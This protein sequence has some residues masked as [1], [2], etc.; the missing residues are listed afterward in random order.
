MKFKNI[1]IYILA[2]I[3]IVFGVLCLVGWAPRTPEPDLDISEI[4]GILDE[5]AD[6]AI[7]QAKDR[8]TEQKARIAA[9]KN[10][11]KSIPINT[12]SD[13]TNPEA[14]Y[15]AKTLYG[16]AGFLDEYERSLVAWCILNRV[17][18]GLGGNTVGEVVS[19]PRQFDGY[20]STNPVTQEN[21]D[22]AVDVL[23]RWE[24]EKNGEEDV[25]RTLPAEY[26]YF[27]G[28]GKHNYFRDEFLSNES[29]YK[30]GTEGVYD[31]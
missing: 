16:E 20:S 30:F 2:M 15:I 7:A 28:D 27:V 13:Y 18:E 31:K 22:L 23:E 6:K 17:D 10:V 14:I 8:V 29:T 5:A 25:G 4:K 1:I 12:D 26:D 11:V 19:A 3:I 9:T 21:Y 24:A